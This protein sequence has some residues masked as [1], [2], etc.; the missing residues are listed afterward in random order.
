M[1]ERKTSRKKK[2]GLPPGSLVYL[3][4]HSGAPVKIKVFSYGPNQ[5]EEKD[6]GGIDECFAYKDKAEI[7]W[8][9]LDGIH[10]VEKVAKLC[11][12]FSIH[13]LVVE[14]ILNS[15]QR[16]KKA[17]YD[18]YVFVVFKMLYRNRRV[19]LQAE[20]VSLV[21][22]RNFVIS[23]QEESEHD[24]FDVV[25]ERLR[26][27]VGP[28]RKNGTDYLAYSLIDTVVD[29][30][31]VVLEDL[32]EKLETLEAEILRSPSEHTVHETQKIKKD[33]MILRRSVWP[34]RELVG[35][36]GRESSALIQSSTLIYFRDIYDHLI[37]IVDIVEMYREIV[38]NLFEIYLSSLNNKI[39]YVMKVLAIVTTI[40]MPLT[41]ISSIYGM[42]F[43]HMPELKWVYGYPIVLF[44]MLILALGMVHLFRRKN[45]L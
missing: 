16:P 20:Q 11:A 39:N 40:F 10:D 41:F 44:V 34:L 26:K 9:N 33:M 2:T 23:F 5:F 1:S 4:E 29:H 14:D 15:N 21:F 22:G 8:I 3:G 43:E 38:G 45:W 12:Y 27:G 24:V 13:P 28:L 31:F 7:S 18:D 17:V 25:R 19:A 30:Y 42:N 37:E 36:L 35:S 32:G 6:L